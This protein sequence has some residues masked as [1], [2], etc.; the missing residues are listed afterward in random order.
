MGAIHDRIAARLYQIR[1]NRLQ[2][3]LGL[4]E[5]KAA[6]IA[7]RWAYFDEETIDRRREM[8]QIRQHSN[9]LLL[10]PGSEEEKNV[11][12]RPLMD[13]FGVLRQQQQDAR[14][15]L[16]DDIRGSLT[17]TQQGRFILL[18]EEMQRVVQDTIQ[19]LRK[20]H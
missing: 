9:D 11:K 1:V 6:S 4:S 8:R 7:K 13:R 5:D 18:E 16:E 2:Q 15:K 19:E 10:G 14:K 20:D 3:S 17:P 12:L